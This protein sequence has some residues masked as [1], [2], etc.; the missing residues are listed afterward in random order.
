[1]L[2]ADT[3]SAESLFGPEAVERGRRY[4]RPL[5]AALVG[6]LA[7]SLGTLAVL[8][9]ATPGDRL[10]GLVDGLPWW[11]ETPSFGAVVTVVLAIVRLPLGLWR[12][13]VRERRW[14]LSTQSLGGFLVDRAKSTAVGAVLTAVML[15]GLA[16]LVRLFPGAW[17]LAAAAAGAA[18]VVV[19]GLIAPLVLEPLFNRFQPL[20]DEGLARALR[21]LAERAGAPVREV[22]VADASRRTTKAN[23]YVSGLGRTRRL[24]LYDTLL[25]ASPRQEVEAVVAH[26]LGHR[27]ARHVARATALG[28][29]AAALAA[30]VLWL[31]LGDGSGD[32]R[33]A[34]H[35]LLLL[36]VLELLALPL[37]AAVSRRWERAAD[38]FAVLVTN[39][40][41]GLEAAFRR[42]AETNV[43]DL[44]P[45]WAVRVLLSSHPPLPE[46]IAAVRQ[47]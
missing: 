11:L 26:E 21:E 38:R 12:G 6:D 28:M 44:A 23:A 47:S 37:G 4:H 2:R 14:A 17:P 18:L 46:R 3:P 31:V 30:V 45:P 34:P 13:W 29:A 41:A 32:A 15:L 42:L 27:R 19:L 40:P 7:L 22:L 20:G 39:D 35:V 9:F 25:N 24:V 33:K 1:L 8:A 36:G 16:A 10:L 43:A 5:Y